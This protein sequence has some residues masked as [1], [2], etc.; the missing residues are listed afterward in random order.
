LYYDYWKEEIPIT[1]SFIVGLPHE[2]KDTINNTYNWVKTSPIN[3]VFFPLALT[4][5][6]YY[7]SEFNTDYEKYG[8]KLDLTTGYWENEHF[9]YNEA[10]S[11]AEQYN[12]ELL[13]QDNYPSSWFLMTLLNH[14]YTIEQLKQTKI[15]D[16]NFKKILRARE[17][18]LKEYKD[19]LLK[20]NIDNLIGANNDPS[21]THSNFSRPH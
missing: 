11:L 9:N 20:I 6:T 10:T 16:L 1:C 17:T 21:Q 8:Y 19:K 3:S 14:G 7:K 12:E 15:K 13:R 2:T 18:R 4:N 5:K